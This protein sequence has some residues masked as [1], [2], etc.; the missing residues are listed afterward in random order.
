ML[1][2]W[3]N[4]SVTVERAPWDQVRGTTERDW[5]SATTATVGGCHVQP[6][7]TSQDLGELRAQA[8]E[9]KATLYAPPGADVQTGDRITC[10]MGTFVV[11]GDP[12]PWRSPTGAVSH[13]QV[14]L[15]EWRG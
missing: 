4:E 8:V 7:T 1:P 12:E 6:S 14:R 11:Y 15:A 10:A 9:T 13:V 5:A 2:S 3:F